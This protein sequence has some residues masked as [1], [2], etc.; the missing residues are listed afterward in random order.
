MNPDLTLYKE[1]IIQK[2][3]QVFS[4]VEGAISF[5]NED[6]K[7]CVILVENYSDLSDELLN[8]LHEELQTKYNYAEKS[9]IC[10]ILNAPEENKLEIARDPYFFLKIFVDDIHILPEY[11]NKDIV[12]EFKPAMSAEELNGDYN[13]DPFLFYEA[14]ACVNFYRFLSTVRENKIVK[15]PPIISM[16]GLSWYRYMTNKFFIENLTKPE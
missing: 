6:C 15:Y 12:I 9:T 1:Q 14:I 10:V 16:Y 13:I 2:N 3:Y 7:T 8:S 11:L 4:E 5:N